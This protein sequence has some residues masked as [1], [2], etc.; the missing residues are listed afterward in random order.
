MVAID[1]R[2]PVNSRARWPSRYATRMDNKPTLD[3]AEVRRTVTDF[4]AIPVLIFWALLSF[5]P[6][7]GLMQ[8]GGPFRVTLNLF[9]LAT[10]LWGVLL[11]VLIIKGLMWSHYR[12][13]AMSGFNRTM[14][15]VYGG[16][17]SVLYLVFIRTPV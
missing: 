17:W 14:L 2:Q 3:S 1:A 6:F 10:G 9:F 15:A 12:N 13:M 8:G 16:V 11:G 5:G 7:G 4:I